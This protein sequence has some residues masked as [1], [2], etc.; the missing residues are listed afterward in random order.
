[1]YH[2]GSEECFWLV[3][4]SLDGFVQMSMELRFYGFWYPLQVVCA[5][6]GLGGREWEL[7]WGELSPPETP[8]SA[9]II[10][11]SIKQV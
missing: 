3:I 4:H 10:Y 2:E 11:Q 8:S 1:M 5:C 9:L 6:E 7:G